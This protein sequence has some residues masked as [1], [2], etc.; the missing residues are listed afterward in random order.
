MS[1]DL[2]RKAVYKGQLLT[3]L[4][5]DT[6]YKNETLPD[7]GKR[8][9][10]FLESESYYEEV[11]LQALLAQIKEAGSKHTLEPNEENNLREF[12]KANLMMGSVHSITHEN[13]LLRYM[14]YEY[15]LSRIEHDDAGFDLAEN[16]PIARAAK[17]KAEYA[18]TKTEESSSAGIFSSIKRKAKGVV[19]QVEKATEVQSTTEYIH[20]QCLERY[21]L[22]SSEGYSFD[23]AASAKLLMKRLVELNK[24]TDKGIFSRF[25]SLLFKIIPDSFIRNQIKES[26]GDDEAGQEKMAFVE[27]IKRETGCTYGDIALARIQDGSSDVVFVINHVLEGAMEQAKQ[28]ARAA[29]AGNSPS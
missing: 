19:K 16:N 10:K 5:N 14:R 17:A 27:Q 2:S 26:C 15:L 22:K 20:N 9:A 24:S 1:G 23:N 12:V 11:L 3:M 13:P 8:L 6:H 4:Q 18:A 29:N 25:V 7:Y 21:Y 28:H